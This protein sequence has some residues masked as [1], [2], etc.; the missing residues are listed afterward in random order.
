M[1]NHL[2]SPIAINGK[3]LKNRCVVSAMV[4]NL[5][6]ADGT[7][8]E[9][10]AAYHEAKAAGG[11]AMIITEDFAI[12]NVA[13][14]GHMYIGGLWKDEHIPGFKEYTDRLHKHGA[15]SIVQLHHPGRQAPSAISGFTPWAPSAIP[16][17]Y[18]PDDM[19]HEMTIQEI[20][21]VVREFGQAARRAKE[22]GFDGCELHGAHGYLINEFMSLYSNKRTDEYG[23]DMLNRLR[24]PIEIIHEVRRQAGDDFI[25]GFKI[26]A[27]EYVSGGL[28]I[29]DTKAMVP[30][31][32]KAGIDYINVSVGV[33][34]TGD[35]IIPS[36]Y[37]KHA[38]IAD[39]AAEIK[40][41]VDHIPVITVGRINDTRIA[42][43]VIASGK[44]D[45]VAFGRQSIA[46]P[47][48]P[49]KAQAGRFAEIR[50]CVGCLHGCDDN[51]N[52]E[53]PG[54][55]ELNPIIGHE[56]EPE[57][58][59]VLTDNPK[60]VLV[61]GAGPAG[62]E[63]AIGAA[64]CGHK[65]Q[66]FDKER[67][68]GGKYRLASVP[69][70]KGELAAFIS[71]QMNELKN[72]N[73]PVTLET[74]VTKELV[75]AMK[76]DVVI[77]A[78]GTNP[79][80]LKSIPGWDRP[81]VVMGTDVLSGKANTGHRVVVIG[82]GHAGAE[83]AN[84]IASNMKEV[85]IVELQNGIALDE[86]ETPRNYLLADMARNNIRFCTES[87]VSEIKEN[88]VVITGKYNEEIPVDT[89][90]ISVGH[91]PNTTLAEELRSAGYDVRTVGDCNKV[92]LVGPAVR[93]GYLAGRHI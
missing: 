2:F 73:V 18:S 92:G 43:A 64:K 81:N 11:F 32:E 91:R 93:E 38:W 70:C 84:H 51:V 86:V 3:Q 82:G 57:Y 4:M 8:T 37:T 39:K 89:V 15:L 75:D 28:T 31:L 49:N 61:I 87:S 83:T 68:A 60:R 50:T 27:E 17:P 80:V 12:T 9:R 26:S 23:G 20:N 56:S 52:N 30:F 25:V 6:E 54:T 85:T 76:P 19:P 40:S 10:F 66:V 72:L 67:W 41:V 22:A 59:T 65:V 16:C 35:V 47:E 45:L 77:A 44:A 74:V 5:C 55:C 33:Y 62:L 34:R 14:K 53:R 24:F 48:T 29:E 69:P 46:D 21:E 71:W 13:G 90:V 79:V 7:C 1:L 42:D 78:T 36:M 88:S 63:A 58:Q